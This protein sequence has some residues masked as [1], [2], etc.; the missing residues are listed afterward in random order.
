MKVRRTL[1]VK[2]SLEWLCEAELMAIGIGDVEIP[3]PPLRVSG[4]GLRF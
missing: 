2:E 4:S 1:R 3:F